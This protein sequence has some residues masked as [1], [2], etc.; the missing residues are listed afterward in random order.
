MARA[1]VSSA[2]EPAWFTDASHDNEGYVYDFNLYSQSPFLF[3]FNYDNWNTD[4]NISYILTLYQNNSSK[5]VRFP[6]FKNEA[7]VFI[8][9]ITGKFPLTKTDIQVQR[10]NN[11]ICTYAVEKGEVKYFVK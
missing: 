5:N 10:Y 11:A 8:Y 7:C 1:V 2:K 3:G 4:D 9:T 6:T